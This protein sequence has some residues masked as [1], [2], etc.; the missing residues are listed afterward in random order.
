MILST[1]QVAAVRQL[2]RIRLWF[3]RNVWRQAWMADS[4]AEPSVQERMLVDHIRC[5]AFREA[6][7]RTVKPGDVVVDLGAGTGLLS[8][9]ALEAGASHVYAIEMSRIAEVMTEL[10]DANGFRDRVTLIRQNSRKAKLP[11]LCD[12]L[13][14]ETLS[15]FCF[16]TEHIIATVADA[17]ARFL[18]PGARVIPESAETFLLPISSEAFGP[19]RFPARFYGLDYQPFRKRLFT[20]HFLAEA[21]TRP[22]QALS[23]PGPC[24]RV[25]FRKDTQNPGKTFV[26][27][28]INADGRLDGFLGWFDARLCEGVQ[29]CNAPDLPLTSWWQL[30]LPVLEQPQLRAGQTILL[31]LDPHITAGEAQW[32]YRVQLAGAESLTG[33]AVAK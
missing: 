30:F 12:V 3:K 10:I 1:R 7:R 31:Q 32:S 5:D 24:Y 13:I 18:K 20:D 21:S 33:A 23:K 2:R 27:F 8:F 4:F 29:L 19:G 22:Y 28:R 16:D 11:E 9:F 14:S 26:P 15:T 6:I 17:R 25:D